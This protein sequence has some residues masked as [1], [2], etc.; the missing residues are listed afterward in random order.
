MRRSRGGVV[1]PSVRGG[2]E[3]EERMIP[4]LTP[5]QK[6]SLKTLADRT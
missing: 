2:G 5:V 4:R 6:R 3:R 1:S